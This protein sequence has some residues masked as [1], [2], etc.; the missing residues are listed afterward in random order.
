MGTAAAETPDHLGGI[1]AH[2]HAATPHSIRELLKHALTGAQKRKRGLPSPKKRCPS[3]S[4][5]C[6]IEH[7]RTCEPVGAHSAKKN[8]SAAQ[9]KALPATARP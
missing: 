7:R 3:G 4:T 2:D 8:L 1:D 6:R 9:V 5:R